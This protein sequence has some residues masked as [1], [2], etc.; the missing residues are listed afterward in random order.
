MRC[1]LV[2]SRPG[3]PRPAQQQVHAVGRQ[4]IGMNRTSEAARLPGQLLE[5]VLSLAQHAPRKIMKSRAD[6]LGLQAVVVRFTRVF[7]LSFLAPAITKTI[8]QG[9]QPAMLTAKI[10]L[11]Q[12]KL[13]REWPRQRAQLGLA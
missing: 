5:H 3:S 11:L 9:R 12:G 7:R 8:L 1:R 6:G 4:R 13:A 10:L 2:R